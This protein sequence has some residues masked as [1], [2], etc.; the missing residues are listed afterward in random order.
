MGNMTQFSIRRMKPQDGQ[1]V[2]RIDVLTQEEYL[3]IIAWESMGEEERAK[4][5]VSKAPDF[6]V[7]VSAGLCHVAVQQDGQVIGFLL[8]HTDSRLG[9]GIVK[10][11][12]V[13]P[14]KRRWGVGG[15]LYDGLIS[16]AKELSIKHIVAHINQD[17][18][19]SIGLHRKKGFVLKDRIEATLD[20]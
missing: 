1:G 20:L 9:V 8:A 11:I 2:Y 5:L 3:G 4:R 10:H 14:A 15:A 13:D 17:N 6:A 7:M 16:A 18:P 12:A 19:K